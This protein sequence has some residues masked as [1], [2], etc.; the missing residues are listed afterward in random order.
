VRFVLQHLCDS[1]VLFTSISDR[2]ESPRY[3]ER[4]ESN[5]Q[6][7][8]IEQGRQVAT[9]KC[10]VRQCAGCTHHAHQWGMRRLAWTLADASVGQN[11]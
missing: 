2:F 1:I 7:K 10:L 4:T 6:E 9:G 11:F 3:C 5:A 8:P